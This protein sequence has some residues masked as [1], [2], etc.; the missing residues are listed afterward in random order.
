[1]FHCTSQFTPSCCS[2]HASSSLHYKTTSIS[3]Q[4]RMQGQWQPVRLALSQWQQGFF[5][6]NRSSLRLPWLS[7]DLIWKLIC[8][9]SCLLWL[10]SARAVTSMIAYYGHFNR[11]CYLLTYLHSR[12]FI[13]QNNLQPTVTALSFLFAK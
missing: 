8:S 2:K 4:R 5:V 13:E 7:S 10:H 6:L 1:M 3:Y 11:F 9:V 12:T